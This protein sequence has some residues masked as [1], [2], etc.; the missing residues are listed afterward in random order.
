MAEFGYN[1]SVNLSTGASP[2]EAVTGVHPRLPIDLVPLPVD[3]RISADAEH[4]FHQMQPVHNEV[5]WHIFSNNDTYKQ[6]H[7]KHHRFVESAE[8]DTVMVLIRQECL[9]PGTYKKL[10]PR[11]IG[12]YKIL[13]KI[14]SNA[15]VI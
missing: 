14:G 9:P 8:G 15:Y 11:N 4:F 13:K 10:H 3:A 12:P 2:F 6:Q 1:N 5:R 7:E